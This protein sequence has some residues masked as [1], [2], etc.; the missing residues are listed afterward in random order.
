MKKS[1]GFTVVEL[2]I[3]S[4]IIGALLTGVL[5]GVNRCSPNSGVEEEARNYVKSLGINAEGFSCTKYDTDHD[6]YISCS[7]SYKED[8]KLVIL[9]IECA[10]GWGKNDGCRSPK[11]IIRRGLFG[12]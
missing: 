6:G 4:A 2:I 9:P 8:N 7:V 1:R 12:N 3:V 5:L 10:V 11:T